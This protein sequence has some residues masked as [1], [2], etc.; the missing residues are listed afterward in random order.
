MGVGA[1][2]SIHARTLSLA[3][4]LLQFLEASTTAP[5]D[6]PTL[7]HLLRHDPALMANFLDTVR[8]CAPTVI[9]DDGLWLQALV[10]QTSDS[11][12]QRF[13]I[14]CALPWLTLELEQPHW[15]QL[16][17]LL[18]H[19]HQVCELARLLAMQMPDLEVGEAGV[20]GMMANLGR[21]ML[22]SQSPTRFVEA[23]VV[24][25]VTERVL[26]EE[27]RQWG[28]D[29]QELAAR[30]IR[31]WPLDSFV[32]DAVGLLYQ[33]DERYQ[34]S[35]FLVR[36]LHCAQVLFSQP[37]LTATQL[38]SLSAVI[39]LSEQS[40]KECLANA[41]AHASTLGW[42]TLDADAFCA[43]QQEAVRD[44]RSA[45]GSLALRQVSHLELAAG[46]TLTD[47]AETATRQLKAFFSE[48]ALFVVS[49]DRRCLQGLPVSG[50]ASRLASMSAP[51]QPGDNLI[52]HALLEGEVVNSLDEESFALSMLDHQVHQLLGGA[53]F[54]C[55]P[56]AFNEAKMGVMVVRLDSPEQASLLDNH[57]VRGVTANLA[58]VLQGIL[59]NQQAAVPEDPARLV[60]E[61]YH[62]LSNPISTVRNHLYVL[63][64]SADDEIR[65]TLDQVEKDVTRI[66]DLL[67]QY[68]QRAH[69]QQQLSHEVDT[70]R[71]VR[72]T[73]GR[74]L[75]QSGEGRTIELELAEKL[76]SVCVNPLALEQILTNLL[77]NAIEATNEDN[78]ISVTTHGNWFVGDARFVDVTIKDDGPGIPERIRE[79]LFS[80]VNSTKGGD[81]S[82]LGLSI[83][84]NLADEI[85]AMVH[86]QSDRNGTRFQVLVPCQRSDKNNTEAQLHAV[87]QTL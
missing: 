72:E 19:S 61:I 14:R 16:R 10:Q 39:G 67:S 77:S 82:G 5:V 52:S 74:V 58:Q 2:D 84:K 87:K 80:P 65:T 46:R 76:P 62:E 85:G 4:H 50:Q 11:D 60:R 30:R 13:A 9:D 3:H 51:M 66:A 69:N 27:R 44:I 7:I 43:R 63:K 68:R 37:K 25:P 56:L 41:K 42:A 48:T 75:E 18:L 29:H 36:A 81:H 32:G 71:L 12:L 70:N 17:D 6:R 64:R 78:T 57:Q 33:P 21:V 86:C 79:N 54:C 53:G 23:A 26:E 31:Q 38:R 28:T 8:G 15:L 47:L 83:V 55:I 45:L 20:A 59:G 1:S 40:L 24:L 34:N 49:R 73:A 22:F 35:T